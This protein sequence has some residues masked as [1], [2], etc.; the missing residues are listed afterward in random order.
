MKKVILSIILICVLILSGCAGTKYADNA[1][2][3][4]MMIIVDVT[5][6]YTIYADTDT[7]VLYFCR[8]G[9]S[10]KSVTVMYNADGSLK[11]YDGK[12]N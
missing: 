1:T 3:G 7:R 11:L 2:D 5:S 9:G 8:D 12:I 10:G 4:D 6:G